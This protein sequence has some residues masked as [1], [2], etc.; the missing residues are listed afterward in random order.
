[1]IFDFCFKKL[2][3]QSFK[4]FAKFRTNFLLFLVDNIF[5]INLSMK[6]NKK[7]FCISILTIFSFVT[8]WIVLNNNTIVYFDSK[9][10]F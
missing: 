9:T 1:M 2:I 7:L 6:Y 3:F 10:G 8:D 4:R 5:V